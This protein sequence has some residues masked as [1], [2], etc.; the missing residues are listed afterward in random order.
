MNTQITH[1]D[2][3]FDSPDVPPS[4]GHLC[5]VQTKHTWTGRLHNPNWKSRLRQVCCMCERDWEG[6]YL[7]LSSKSSRSASNPANVA[8]NY[9]PPMSMHFPPIS[10]LNMIRTSF[11]AHMSSSL[12]SLAILR[13]R[14]NDERRVAAVCREDCISC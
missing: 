8:F 11:L 6:T 3:A 10:S 9:Q 2:F 5:I 4:F 14:R 1:L 13:I 7:T 12:S